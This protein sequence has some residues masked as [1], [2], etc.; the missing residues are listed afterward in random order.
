MHDFEPI[1]GKLLITKSSNSGKW[2]DNLVGEFVPNLGF[3]DHPRYPEYKSV[4]RDGFV[5]FVAKDDC[6][7]VPVIEVDNG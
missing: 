1:K 7:E 6:V 2:Y 5:N 4:Q 3:F